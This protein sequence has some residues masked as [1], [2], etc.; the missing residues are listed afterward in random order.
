MKYAALI[1]VITSLSLHCYCQNKKFITPY[2][3]IDIHLVKE[4]NKD[5]ISVEVAFENIDK[6][7]VFILD[8]FTSK[9]DFHKRTLEI[10]FGEM[11]INSRD[12]SQSLIEVGNGETKVFRRII[13]NYL[14]DSSIVRLLGGF[15]KVQNP[16]TKNKYVRKDF[17]RWEDYKHVSYTFLANCY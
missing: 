11:L 6:K 12:S 17:S 3:V 16:G 13:P 10:F 4:R 8:S 7:T 2:Y 5:S 14:N 9:W 15:V 1:L